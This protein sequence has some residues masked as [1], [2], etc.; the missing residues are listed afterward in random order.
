MIM[1]AKTIALPWRDVDVTPEQGRG[2]LVDGWNTNCPSYLEDC[3]I[4][5]FA[6]LR[7]PS[8]KYDDV[9]YAVR[10]EITGRKGQRRPYDDRQWVRVKITFVG[11]GEPDTVSRGWMTV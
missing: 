10:I 8:F 9:K 5:E 7:L 4:P 6:P 11:D 1:N 2:V 3:E